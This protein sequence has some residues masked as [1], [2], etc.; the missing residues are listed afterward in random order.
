[1]IKSIQKLLVLATFGGLST[2]SPAQW[3][4]T[5]IHPAGYTQSRALGASEGIIVG[6]SGS[7][8]AGA[9]YWSNG[10]STYV[11]LDDPTWTLSVAYQGNTSVQV[12]AYQKGFIHASKWNGSLATFEDLNP[13]RSSESQ[14]NSLYGNKI[15]GYARFS[16]D[17]HA[18]VWNGG[19]AEDY[20]DLH[21]TDANWSYIS[22]MTSSNQIG[23]VTLT[24]L[25]NHAAVWSG[26]AES[27][28]DL[29]P[30]GSFE[31]EAHAGAG[32]RQ[33]GWSNT[34]VQERHAFLWSGTSA[35]AIDLNPFG[36]LVSDV[37]GMSEQYQVGYSYNSTTEHSSAQ[38]WSGSAASAVNLG[39]FLPADFVH[40]FATSVVEY[41]DRIEVYG[42]GYRR[43]L[44]TSEAL[45]WVQ[46]VPEPASL[47]IIGLGVLGLMS[48]RRNK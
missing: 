28:V 18:V 22:A 6:S 40:S 47:A 48:R 30:V 26:T 45:K 42:Y 44:N 2:L 27:F 31:S 17:A 1:M 38:I 7:L 35:S 39:S 8:N 20:T 15:G 41:D 46:P 4:G 3:V 24:G 10:G 34:L 23:L 16:G 36:E 21:P 13:A 32:N 9:G 12:G 43:G 33:G 19:G 29:A 14:A 25:V 5:S 11:S 37:T